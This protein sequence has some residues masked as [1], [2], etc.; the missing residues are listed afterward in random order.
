MWLDSENDESEEGT[1]FIIK[2]CPIFET[3]KNSFL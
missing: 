2:K 3:C 1:G